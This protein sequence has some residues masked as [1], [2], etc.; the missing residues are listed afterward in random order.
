MYLERG[1]GSHIWDV[2][3][4]EFIDFVCCYGP[5]IV[6]MCNEEVNAAVIEQ[7]NKGNAFVIPTNL[8]NLL[9]ERMVT[10][11]DDMD[12]VMYGKNGSEA[13]TLAVTISRAYTGKKKILTAENA[14][15]GFHYWCSHYKTGI[16]PEYQAHIEHFKYNDIED[17]RRV[18]AENSVTLPVL[19]CVPSSTT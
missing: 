1:K 14:Y 10:L 17:L 5:N 3:G 9:A 2:D 15:H 18:A 13:V 11:I 4:N 12:W 6:G 7:V 8:S 19:C 16:L